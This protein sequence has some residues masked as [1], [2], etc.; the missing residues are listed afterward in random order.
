MR[1]IATLGAV[2]ALGMSG[3]AM[4]A[5][6]V[7]H[8]FVEAGYGYSELA[9]GAFTDGDGFRLAGSFELPANLI[10]A[11]SYSDID[12]KGLTDISA[13]S[14]G[15]GYKWAL[16]TSFDF[17]AAASYEQFDAGSGLDIDGFGLTVGLRGLLTDT[18]EL[19]TSLKYSDLGSS[20]PTFFNASLG[21]RKYFHPSFAAGVELR[22]T[23]LAN[24]GETSLF[25]TARY[26]FGGR[27]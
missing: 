9:G 17:T 8:S 26:D 12:Y 3:A 21:V 11:A 6:G 20:L 1:K 22:K 13:L 27:R 4:A 14:A 15:L 19:S 23:D 16:G 2:V 25:A 5:D 18:V 7:S 24:F 10:V